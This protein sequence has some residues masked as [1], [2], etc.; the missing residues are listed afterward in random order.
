MV[1]IAGKGHETYQIVGVE[2]TPFDDREVASA[3]SPDGARP[4]LTKPQAAKG[5][6]ARRARALAFV[7]RRW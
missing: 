3:V 6:A 7:G 1:V 4:M 2:V 5:P